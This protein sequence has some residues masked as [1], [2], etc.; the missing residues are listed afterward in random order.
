ML[1]HLLQMQKE[2][3]VNIMMMNQAQSAWTLYWR[4]E[5]YVDGQKNEI[6]GKWIFITKYTYIMDK[7]GEFN[8]LYMKGRHQN[9]LKG[10]LGV[11]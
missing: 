9:Y 6:E 10:P 4:M 11:W 2:Q 3:H 8:I 5:L 1:R 7:N